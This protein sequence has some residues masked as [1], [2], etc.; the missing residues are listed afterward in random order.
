VDLGNTVIV[1]EHNLDVIKTADWIIDLGPEAGD[2]GGAIVAVGTP[3]DIVAASAAARAS[4]R[5][6]H[7]ADILADI[8]AA[9]PHAERPRFDPNAAETPRDG[10]LDLEAIGQNAQMPWEVDGRRWHTVERVNHKGGPCRWEGQALEWVDERIHELGEFSD[11]NWNHRSVVE[12]AAPSKSQGW[13][14]HAMTSMESVL[15]L[16]F[17]V[18][19]NAFKQA[20]L[21]ARLGIRPLNQTEGLQVYGDQERVWVTN[22]KGPW[23]S[24]TV[25]VHRL[26]EIDTPAFQ[27]FLAQGVASFQANL[28]RLQTKPEDVMPWKVN[29]QR[30][31]LGD[32][33]FPFGQRTQWDRA[34]LPRLLDLVRELEPNME[35]TWTTRDAI[36]LKVPGINRSWA[37]WRTK[38]SQGLTCRFLGKKGQFNL[39]RVERFGVSPSIIDGRSDGDVLQLMFQHDDHVHAAQ[40]KELLAEHLRGFRDLFGQ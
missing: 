24:V 38:D 28:K 8:L 10:D 35:V 33:G 27:E 21:L 14:L 40:L 15:R 1:V 36:T 22:H 16:V 26:S 39:S 17:R 31:H 29:G 6:S 13:F 3:E 7:T 30:W 25:L 2:A 37:Q 11:T 5:P 23:Q 9:G 18:G 4:G 20:D 12:I 19:K 34:L 32:K